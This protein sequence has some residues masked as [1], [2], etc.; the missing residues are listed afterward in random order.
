VLFG[1]SFI[2]FTTAAA[3][4]PLPLP[5]F[6]A[7]KGSLAAQFDYRPEYTRHVP[8]FDSANRPYI[9]SRTSSQDD[10]SY[11]GS[12][13]DGGWARSSIVD[14][15]AA[16]YPD[17]AGMLGAGGYASDR[18]VFDRQDRAYTVLTI[19]LEDGDFR[20]L[21]LYSFDRCATW[22]VCELPFGDELPRFSDRNRGTVACE[23]YTGHNLSDGPPFIAVWRELSDWPGSW[24]TRNELWVLQPYFEDDRLIVPDPTFVTDRFLGMVQSAGGS[25]FAATRGGQTF[26]VWTQVTSDRR[27]GTPTYVGI[28]DQATRSVTMRRRIALA[29][30]GNDVHDT[31][32]IC[33]DSQGVLHVVT[34]AHGRAMLYTRTLA[35]GNITAWST[36][37][38]ILTSGYVARTS[39]ADGDARQTYLAMVCDQTDVLHVVCRQARRN[40]SSLYWGRGYSTLLYLRKP[41]DGAWS[42]GRQLVIPSDGSGYVNYY[43]KLAIDHRGRLYLSFNMFRPTDPQWLRPFVRFRQRMVLWSADGASWQFATTPTFEDGLLQTDASMPYDD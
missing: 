15:L 17:F 37:A 30:P 28:Y 32:G 29:Q 40:V 27:Q 23:Y 21:L 20:N 2:A 36:P 1:L 34:G 11:V 8:S 9:R 31:P 18:I 4:A 35:P 42:R 39:D 26:F 43:H 38:P 33:L 25:S 12:L 14:A 5:Y 16:A 13:V 7:T 41:A 19:R 22:Q 10:T 3:A 24:A 6:M